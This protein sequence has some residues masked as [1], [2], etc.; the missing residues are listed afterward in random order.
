MLAYDFETNHW[1]EV[2]CSNGERPSGRSSLVAQVYEN[3]LY[4]FGG[5]NGQN[6]MNDMFKFRLKPVNI[7]P[8]GLVTDLRKLMMREDLSDV[9]FLV[10]GREVHANRS[11]LAI[12]SAYFEAML[13][14]GMSESMKVVDPDGNGEQQRAPIEMQDISHNVFLKVLEYL[15]TDTVSDVNWDMGI[16]LLIASEQ[17]MLDRLKAL[18]QDCLRRDI[19]VENVISVLITSH[20]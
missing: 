4:I 3:C 16:S 10:E 19:A 8:S 17:F 9:T 6:V 15:Y 13:F 14:G 1:T 7:P 5:Y 12:R 18:C 20:R 11:L 2:D